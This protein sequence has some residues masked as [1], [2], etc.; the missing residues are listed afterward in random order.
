MRRPTMLDSALLGVVVAATAV[1][2]S[3]C[4]S[5]ATTSPTSPSASTTTE[6]F[7]GSLAQSGSAAHS[8]TVAAKGTV[9]VSLTAVSPL[10]TMSLGVALGTWDGTTCG[11]SVAENK[12]ARSGSTALTGTAA[13]GNYCVRVFDSGN[14]PSDWSVSYSIDVVHP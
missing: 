12:D 8:F 2:L 13:T 6:S 14:I 11:T 3:G 10:T 1:A 5:S 4:D 9:T 7:S